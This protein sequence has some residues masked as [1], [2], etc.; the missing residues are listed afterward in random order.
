MEAEGTGLRWWEQNR[1][2]QER[3]PRLL[4]LLRRFNGRILFPSFVSMWYQDRS[5]GVMEL[6]YTKGLH[7]TGRLN[8]L[9]IYIGKE[10]FRGLRRL[11]VFGAHSEPLSAECIITSLFNIF[12]KC[13]TS[14]PRDLCIPRC[15]RIPL[16]YFKNSSL[17]F[18]LLNSTRV[19]SF[20]KRC[21][22]RLTC[23]FMVKY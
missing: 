3:S 10:N 13:F 2:G 11:R 23:Y 12:H 5:Y 15:S 21:T 9:M 22:C 1:E 7:V 18:H 4:F 14:T 8:M 6:S 19:S 16:P 20:L 17:M